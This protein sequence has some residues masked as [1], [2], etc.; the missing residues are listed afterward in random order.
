MYILD[1]FEGETARIEATDEAGRI[2]FFNVPRSAL[3]HQAKEGDVL[4]KAEENTWQ[5]DALYTEKCRQAMAIRLQKLQ[6]NS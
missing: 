2:N 4:Q 5:V 6:N 1:R 3:P